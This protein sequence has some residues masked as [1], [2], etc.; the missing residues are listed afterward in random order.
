[1]LFIEM[2]ANFLKRGLLQLISDCAADLA[3]GILAFARAGKIDWTAP[4]C[5][6]WFFYSFADTA[7]FSVPEW[8]DKMSKEDLCGNT[9]PGVAL[10]KV[11]FHFLKEF[12][13]VPVSRELA[14]AMWACYK[15][16]GTDFKE[17]LW[18]GEN[19]VFLQ[20]LTTD[21]AGDVLK[22]IDD[23]EDSWYI[24]STVTAE[25]EATNDIHG[26]FRE[27]WRV[28]EDGDDAAPTTIVVVIELAR[29]GTKI[30][31]KIATMSNSKTDSK[32]K[33]VETRGTEGTIRGQF[34]AGGGGGG[35]GSYPGTK[36]GAGRCTVGTPE[37]GG[38]TVQDGSRS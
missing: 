27:V 9:L 19:C 23:E 28:C 24:E 32:V 15:A 11:A 2:R 4:D 25:E 12:C 17:I 38:R 22:G 7:I 31:R 3:A 29:E 18:L 33:L 14:K 30:K 8:Q 34:T 1:M 37:V 26:K 13:S 21:C 36:S 20:S 10:A 16:D 6:S 35:M 5:V